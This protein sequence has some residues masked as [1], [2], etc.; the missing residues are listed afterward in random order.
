MQAAAT[1]TPPDKHSSELHRQ[2]HSCLLR[3][4]HT[5][6]KTRTAPANS[7]CRT[8]PARG[9]S[10]GWRAPGRPA[11]RSGPARRAGRQPPPSCSW[12]PGRSERTRTRVVRLTGELHI[13]SLMKCTPRPRMHAALTTSAASRCSRSPTWHA[14]GCAL[15][16]AGRELKP[17][18]VYHAQGVA[19]MRCDPEAQPCRRRAQQ[20][21]LGSCGRRKHA[22]SALPAFVRPRGP[23]APHCLAGARPRRRER[24]AHRGRLGH[25][26]TQ[27]ALRER[28]QPVVAVA[29]RRRHLLRAKDFTGLSSG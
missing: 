10:E 8:A 19:A 25:L 14:T 2:P 12:S 16:R 9:A 21:S 27:H 23:C 28:A 3:S 4:C 5:D 7:C 18:I 24:G 20:A 13:V 26:R 29:Q 15:G 11:Q 22:W 1:D 17:H 6:T